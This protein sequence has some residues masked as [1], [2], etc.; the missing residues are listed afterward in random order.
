M[1]FYYSIFLYYHYFN[2]VCLLVSSFTS[3]A[4]ALLCQAHLPD[5]GRADAG[6]VVKLDDEPQQRLR[7]RNEEPDVGGH[8]DPLGHGVQAVD[9]E[10]DG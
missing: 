6:R 10:D 2:T 1:F 5:D 3:L 7:R 9:C 8:D 4:L